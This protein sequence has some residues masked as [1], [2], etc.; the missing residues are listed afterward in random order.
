MGCSYIEDI[1]RRGYRTGRRFGGEALRGMPEAMARGAAV[2]RG[3]YPSIYHGGKGNE[4]DPIR[5]FGGFP[6]VIGM[7]LRRRGGVPSSGGKSRGKNE[8]QWLFGKLLF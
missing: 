7:L 5:A 1:I 2:T 8:L 3:Y 6:G 4:K